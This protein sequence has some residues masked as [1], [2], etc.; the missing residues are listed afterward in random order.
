M[1]GGAKF[2]S[3]LSVIGEFRGL[4]GFK[5]KKQKTPTTTTYIVFTEN[6]S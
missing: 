1:F 4:L 6:K 2:S 5:K 3:N